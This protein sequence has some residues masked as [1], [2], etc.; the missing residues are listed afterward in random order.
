MR[1][2]PQGV[3]QLAQAL[4]D[5][6][7]KRQI[8]AV[9]DDGQV[10]QL[11]DNSGEQTVND[12]YLREEYPPAGKV[13][14]PRPGDTPTDHYDNRLSELSTAV[15]NLV[16]AFEALAGVVGD[17][18]RPLVEATGL[19]GKLAEIWRGRLKHIDEEL[20]MWGRTFQR[21]YRATAQAAEQPTHAAED[22]ID[23]QEVDV[24]ADAENWDEPVGVDG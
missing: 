14:A 2:T 19:D 22:S 5:F 11:A 7:S 8:R 17:D 21:R 10:K 20:L 24:Y 9:D 4:Q 16:A 12:I 6:A 15:D 18:G 1:Q 23:D 13:R 3:Y